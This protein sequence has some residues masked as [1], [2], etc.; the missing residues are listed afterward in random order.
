MQNGIGYQAT[1]LGQ[2]SAEQ[3]SAEQDSA[4]QDN[5]EQDNYEPTCAQQVDSDY[6][7]GE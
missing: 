5:Y 4:E 6:G 3:N 7:S 1:R 2:N